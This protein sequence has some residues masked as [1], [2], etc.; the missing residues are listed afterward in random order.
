[1]KNSLL[2]TLLVGS[3]FIVSLMLQAQ[4]PGPGD[5]G[6]GA[7]VPLDGGLLMGLLAAGG[8][9]SAFLKKKK[10]DE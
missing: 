9:L 5:P 1:M 6:G 3:L 10:K 2:K 8:I 4:I 7:S